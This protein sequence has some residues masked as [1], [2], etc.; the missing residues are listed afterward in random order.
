MTLWHL[1]VQQGWYCC[2]LVDGANMTGYFVS[3]FT[4]DEIRNL[5]AIQ[6][7]IHALP[8]HDHCW[9]L[10][11]ACHTSL[12]QELSPAMTKYFQLRRANSDHF[13][14]AIQSHCSQI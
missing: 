11:V 10:P 6:V 5:S 8:N 1:L 7:W 9:T 4:L 13:S 2:R 14:H 3:D 12:Q